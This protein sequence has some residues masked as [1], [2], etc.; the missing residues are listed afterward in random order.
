MLR[1]VYSPVHEMQVV[2]DDVGHK[3][4][5]SGVWFDSPVKAK[6]YKEK[7]ENDIKQE[8]DVKK[9][10]ANIRSNKHETK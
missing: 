2:E 10:K 5:A 8:L 6:A 1:C 9:P 4:M 7:V 3:M